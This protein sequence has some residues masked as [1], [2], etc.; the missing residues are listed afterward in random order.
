MT[1]ETR[2]LEAVEA[3]EKKRKEEEEKKQQEYVDCQ[4]TL[5]DARILMKN[6][7]RREPLGTDR[8]HSR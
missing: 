5:A 3:A 1:K 2:A 4:Q 6:C 7:Q 8:N